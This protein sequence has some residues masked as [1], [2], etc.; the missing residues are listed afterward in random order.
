MAENEKNII[1]KNIFKN[2]KNTIT[3]QLYT[4]AILKLINISEKN[5]DIIFSK[6]CDSYAEL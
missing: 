4:E 6:R 5:K 1:V 2:G 3:T